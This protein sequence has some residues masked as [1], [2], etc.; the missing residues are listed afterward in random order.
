[1][2]W[3]FDDW[4]WIALIVGAVLLYFR[5][6]FVRGPTNVTTTEMPQ[7]AGAANGMDRSQPDA[8]QTQQHRHHGCC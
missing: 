4:V 7:H 2:D 6:D 5:G 3:I 1:M 8:A